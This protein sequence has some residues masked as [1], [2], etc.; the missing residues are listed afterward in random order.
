MR[1][2]MRGSIR[3]IIGYLV[4][5]V[6]AL[7]LSA[8][9]VNDD[10]RELILQAQQAYRSDMNERPVVTDKVIKTYITGIV[11]R[12]IPKQKQLPE[13]TKL[14]VTILESPQPEL[15][16]YVDGHIVMTMGIVYAMENEAQLAGVMAHEVAN[17]AEGYYLSMYQEIKAAE[18]A[19]RSRAGAGA[20]FS[21][22]LDIAV[23]YAV[24]RE[25]IR[26]TEAWMSNDATYGT[27]MKKMAA[28]HAAQSAYYEIKDVVDSIPAKDAD[29]NWLDPRLRFEPVADA[30]GME[31]T[32]LAGYDVEETAKGWQHL[33]R[34]KSDLIKKKEAGMGEFAAQL[35]QTQALM[36]IHTYRMRQSLGASGLVQ[37]RSDIPPTRA[38]FA[39]SLVNL[40][41]VKTAQKVHKPSKY[42]KPYMAFL[43]SSLFPRA[44]K[45]MKEENYEK[46]Y[47]AYEALWS[48][49]IHTAP[50]AYGLAK[51]Q[52]GD[53]AFGASESEKESAEK[54]YEDAI[55]LDS[56]YALP[57]KGLGELY[58]DWE[59]YGDAAKAYKSYVKLAPKAKDR[60]RIERKIK[61]MERK[62][63][64]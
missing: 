21:G 59:R 55:K 6:L 25:S 43:H 33:Y 3:L 38:E 8:V 42:R 63:E 46:A 24:E 32:A 52:L 48:R 53:F 14:S 2:H 5:C 23:D 60:K 39:K 7:N 51:C 9:E 16:S 35:R 44:E 4:V 40:K 57:Y 31:Y 19:E 37:T 28:T 27:T 50:V 62:A 49:G 15:Y 20:L 54:A 61:V 58:G 34:V 47:T 10:G 45:L 13:G 11:Q 30:Q 64:R 41:E 17:V 26:Q 36:E 56:K 1:E 12:L 29:G 18:R 22:L